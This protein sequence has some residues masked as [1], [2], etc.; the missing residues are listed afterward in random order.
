MLHQMV[1]YQEPFQSIVSGRKVVEI[2][3]NDQ[4]RQ[5]IQVA[6]QIEFT[7][8]STNEQVVVK[9]TARQ[10]FKNFREL[11]KQIPLEQIDCIGWSMEELLKETYCIYSEEA[12][13]KFGA[14]ALT[15]ELATTAGNK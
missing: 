8:L 5:V 10:S 1:L 11:Y 3:L 15:I 6:D 2:R 4:K 13:K 12:E 14:L 7:N 9:V